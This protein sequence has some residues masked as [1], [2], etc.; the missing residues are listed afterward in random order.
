MSEK[1]PKKEIV[2]DT[3]SEISKRRVEDIWR[4]YTVK[5]ARMEGE[6]RMEMS[7]GENTRTP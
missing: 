4:L 5:M 2:R 6:S 7:K 3:P 1:R